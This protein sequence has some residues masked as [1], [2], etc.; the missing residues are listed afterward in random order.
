[1]RT[2]KCPECYRVS[3]HEDKKVLVICKGCQCEMEEIK[4]EV[5]QNGKKRIR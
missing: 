5:K 3:E 1:M 2:Y 4:K